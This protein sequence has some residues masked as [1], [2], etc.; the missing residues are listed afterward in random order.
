MEFSVLQKSPDLNRLEYILSKDFQSYRGNDNAS[1]E[2]VLVLSPNGK[3]I[4]VP[5]VNGTVSI[6]DLK[7][8]LL[9]DLKEH[10]GEVNQIAFT[11]SGNQLVS[12]GTDN[13]VRLWDLRKK[14]LVEIKI[15]PEQIDRIK[16]SKNKKHHLDIERLGQFPR[17]IHVKDQ[18][19]NPVFATPRFDVHPSL[20]SVV[21]LSP[22]GM[23]L[24]SANGDTIRLWN[25]S[26]KLFQL[27]E[28]DN[29]DK[30]EP[31][32][33]K[34][35]FSADG[36]LLVA[37]K[38]DGT[39]KL[40]K[41]EGFDELLVKGCNLVRDYL[42]NNLNVQESDRRLCDGIPSPALAKIGDETGLARQKQPE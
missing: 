6:M 42:K 35:Y 32:I 14:Q 11:P 1:L 17:S 24:A 16:P 21:A 36:E 9:F 23:L 8:E 4:A 40:W 10:K 20:P 33:E 39:V 13:T 30:Y 26:G 19:D 15:T 3:R 18:F 37:K 7:G 25:S 41:I 27:I 12:T 38:N 34:I 31:H 28:F 5:K 29:N 2:L 22:D